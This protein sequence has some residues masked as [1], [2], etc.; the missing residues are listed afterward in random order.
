MAIFEN[1]YLKIERAEEQVGEIEDLINK[2]PPF[3]YVLE[4][5][6]LYR[7]RATLAKK[8]HLALN[9][10][11]IRC[12][13]VFHNL[14]SAIDQSYWEAISPKIE[15]E[16]KAKSIQFPFAKDSETLEQT[17]KSRQGHIL[18]DE[19]FNA[20]KSLNPHAG[21]GGNQ[22][23]VLLHEVNIDDKHKFPI[24]A[25]NFSKIDSKAIQLHV[26]DFP[27]GM[28]D[29]GAGW[30]QKDVEWSLSSYEKRDISS[31]VPP[32]TSLYHRVLEL[33]VETWFYIDKANYYGEVGETLKCLCGET[34]RAL[35]TLREALNEI[36]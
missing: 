5:D 1:S 9:R 3:S 12:G 8:N 2:T 16:K 36:A 17:I 6:I 22:M 28:S 23:L 35:D 11:V 21:V 10:I 19:F 29:C 25:G 24:P 7:K 4:T 20:I 18:G 32:T 27:S 34:K 31:I 15:N 30:S 13:E 33:P 14:R 26:P